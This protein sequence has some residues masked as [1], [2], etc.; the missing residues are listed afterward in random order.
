MF[1]ST[2]LCNCRFIHWQLKSHAKRLPSSIPPT[3]WLGAKIQPGCQS[4]LLQTAVGEN[5]ELYARA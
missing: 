5:S 1:A 4:N 3:H 2:Y